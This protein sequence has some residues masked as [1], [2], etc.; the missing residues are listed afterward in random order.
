[1]HLGAARRLTV[2]NDATGIAR[3]VAWASPGALVVMEASGGDE[4]LAHRDLS[5][6][7]LRVAIV[8]AKRVRDFAKASGRPAKADGVDAEVIARYGRVG[9]AGSDAGADAAGR[10]LAELL[11]FRQRLVSEITARQQ[12]PGQL[13]TP[14]LRRRAQADLARLRRDKAEFELLLRRA[15][16]R[17]PSLAAASPCSPACRGSA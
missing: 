10:E 6:R 1:L 12:Q 7:G 8:N 16:R 4:R 2:G 13:E 5:A 11:A 3:L 17:A 14:L 15:I 9:P